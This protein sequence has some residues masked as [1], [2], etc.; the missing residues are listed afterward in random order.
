VLGAVVGV[1]DSFV[2]ERWGHLRNAPLEPFVI[3]M[4]WTICCCAVGL[5]FSSPRLGRLRWFPL[6]VAGPGLL[7]LSRGA[8]PFKQMTQ[9]PS[10][11]VLLVWFAATTIVAILLSLIPLSKSRHTVAY[12][13]ASVVGIGLLVYAAAD[14]RLADWISS[15][16]APN[17]NA[18]NVVLIFLDTSRADDALEITPPAMPHLAA[19]AA[20]ATAFNSAW[21]PASWTVPSHFAVLTGANWWRVPSDSVVGFQYDGV[22]L[23]EQ[24]QSRGYD[25]AAIFANPLLS[26]DAGFSKGFS[27]FTTSRG[28]GVCNSGIGELLYRVLLNDG[29]RMPLCGWFTASEVTARAQRFIRRAHR[30]YMLTVNYLDTHDPYYVPPECRPAGFQHLSRPDR[31]VFLSATPGTR[32]PPAMIVSHARAQYRTAMS[33]ADRSLG[34]LLDV[35]ARDPNTIIAV[36]GDHGEEFVD[37]GHAGH[38]FA[39][40]RESIR[41]PLVLRLPGLPPQKV[42]DPVS[43]TD[44]YASL[45]RA[46]KLFRGDETL[47]LLDARKR[48]PVV[49]TYEF[50]RVPNDAST[51]ERGYSVVAGDY[52]LIFWPQKGEVIYDYRADPAE[53][54]PLGVA[55]IPTVAAPMRQLAARVA[56]DKQRA[57]QFSAVGYMR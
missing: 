7:L 20:T 51:V 37:H 56:R 18:R 4:T 22:R 50:A 6:A 25:T 29:P 39:V 14:V 57:L 11:R 26:S 32:E 5:V 40:Y 15:P 8:T 46:A 27:E 42:T 30:P 17:A 24:F 49:S 34:A 21:A 47:P 3:L 35:A 31:D 10:S 44:L 16:A 43:T 19:F 38:G 54:R 9:W 45:L 41:V 12:S 2:Y 48:R 52:H 36:V 13:V 1:I 55:Q 23:P 28:S 53:G 33:C